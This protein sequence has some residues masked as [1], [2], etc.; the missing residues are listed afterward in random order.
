MALLK[1]DGSLDVER[2]N[3]LPLEEHKKEVG[4]FTREQYK[5]YLSSFPLNEGKEHTK[6]VI[7]S[8]TLTEAIADGYADATEFI[9]NIGRKKGCNDKRR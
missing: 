4:S 6:P 5:E 8:R 2:I 1:E 9:N 7:N 3:K